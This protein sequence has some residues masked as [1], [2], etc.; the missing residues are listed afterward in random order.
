MAK[1]HGA[2]Q[3]KRLAKQKAKRLEKRSLLARRSSKDPTIRLERAEKWPV[4][5]ALMSGEL[6]DEGI[7]YLVIARQEPEGEL[8]FASFLVDVYCLGVKDAFWR[9]GT[10]GDFRDLIQKM[11]EIQSMSPIDPACLAKIV[12]GAVE[13]AQAF[14]FAPHPDYRNASLILAG[15]DPSKCTRQFRFGRDGMP[16]YMQGPNETFAEAM[17]IGERVRAAGGHFLVT[18]IGDDAED[19]M[20]EEEFD[21]TDEPEEDNPAQESH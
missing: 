15:I 19:L 1:K 14:G 3:Q 21:E 7:G 9:A 5:E 18:S 4:V 6:W 10:R 8:I 13:Y 17:A 16:Y 12:K 11:D 2:K 20:I